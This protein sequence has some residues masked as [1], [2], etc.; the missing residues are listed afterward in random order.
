MD[1]ITIIVTLISL[2]G[3]I[4]NS[5]RNKW[6]QVLW[7]FSNLY[8]VVYDFK[9]GAYEQGTLFLAYFI[10]A[11]RGLIVWTKKEKQ[12]KE[13]INVKIKHL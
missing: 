9:I 13:M 5:Q 4:L 7:A 12:D 11:I 2:F 3:T 10:L 8:W 1:I 6:S